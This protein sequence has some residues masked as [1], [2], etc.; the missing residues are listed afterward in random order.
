MKYLTEAIANIS[1][2][3][4]SR[5][6]VLMILL[7]AV[8]GSAIAKPAQ[9]A[10]T[11]NFRFNVFEISV[12][13][14]DLEVFAKT[15]ER[16]GALDM[17]SRYISASD[18][19]AFRRILSERVNVPIVLLSRFLY[20]SQGERSLDILGNFI[21]IA[22]DLSGNRAIRAAA[23]LATADQQNG[24]SLLNFLRKFPT[25]EIY[26]DLQEGLQTVGEL[27]NLLQSTQKVV[28]IV[29][30]EATKLAASPK[31]ISS[32]DQPSIDL[33]D[34]RNP[35]SLKWDR[36]SLKAPS[37]NSKYEIPFYL[38]VPKLPK[39]APISAIVIYPG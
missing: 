36:Y 8:A 30:N 21:K 24:L 23:V 17:A 31:P 18:I 19:I 34:L 5:S 15:G 26:F 28:Q 11:V 1:S 2:Q 12:P 6:A 35:G 22:P 37:L 10:E 3:L 7:S 16:R 14:D 27:S 38:F 25:S 32:A 33:V 9:A 4:I 13:V 39:P 20:T 29:N